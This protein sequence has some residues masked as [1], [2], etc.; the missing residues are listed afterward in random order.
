[1]YGRTFLL[2][3][4]IV[5]GFLGCAVFAVGGCFV[6]RK[7]MF[8]AAGLGNLLNMV[9]YM[10]VAMALAFLASKIVR[11]EEGFSMIGNIVSLGMAFLSGIFVPMEFLGAGVIKLAHFLPAS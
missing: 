2:L 3:G 5:T 1:M 7:E 10:F 9:C 4:T 6:F 8:T 11:N